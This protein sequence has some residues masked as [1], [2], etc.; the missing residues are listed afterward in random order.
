MLVFVCCVVA[1]F[2]CFCVICGKMSCDILFAII[3]VHFCVLN[4]K[5]SITVYI[6]QKMV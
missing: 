3:I 4:Q 5:K 2:V 1:D 6:L